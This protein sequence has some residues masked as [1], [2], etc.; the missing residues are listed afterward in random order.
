M[1]IR[2]VFALVMSAPAVL[3][4]YSCQPGITD[5][6]GQKIDSIVNFYNA[7]KPG[8]QLAVSLDGQVIYSKAWGMAD[9]ENKVPL[10]TETLIEAGSV[11]KQFTA[12]A[13]LLLEK[14]GKLSLDD[15]V[16]KYV[17]ALPSYGHPILIRHLIHHTSGLREWSDI[18]EIAGWP[19][20]LNVPDNQ[21]VLDII[22]RQKSLNSPPG[23]F[24]RYS[25]SNYILLALITEKVSGMTFADFTKKH[26]FE[27][28]GMAHTRWRNDFGEVVPMR[29]QAY[30]VKNAKFRSLMPD[31][32]IHGPGGLLTTAGDLLK[33]NEFY[34]SEKLGGKAMFAKQTA[35]DTLSNGLLNN[36]AAGLFIENNEKRVFHHG[37]ATAGYRAKLVCSP[38]LRLSI[39]WL[40]NTSMLD[41]TGLDPAMEVFK[42]LANSSDILPKPA[43][44]DSVHISPEQLTQFAGLYKSG[45]SG[46][47]V[48]ITSGAE[49]LLLSGTALKMLGNNRFRF[50]DITLSFDGMGELTVTPPSSEPMLYHIT[51][52]PGPAR[53]QEYAGKYYSQEANAWMEVK[54][55]NGKLTA[56]LVPRPAHSMEN[57]R[58]DGFLVPDLKADIVFKRD[59]H[60]NVTALEISTQ[61]SLRIVFERISDH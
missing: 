61:R 13:I 33:W 41:T 7:D 56:H 8:G 29:S 24:F 46:R 10:T 21:A 31:N 44:E 28:A 34:L 25:N 1:K 9:L 18:A 30:E 26:I 23:T 38:D 50:H 15:N 42:I 4:M 58:T 43:K 55:T 3:G 59:L 14:Q 49:G 35:L 17:P 6:T 53:P 48:E 47:D 2:S 20:A 57:Y 52:R 39:A 45:H 36:Y 12:A 60:N 32:A 16:V 37:G 19:L 54:N 5:V 11:S 22:C 27:P 51:D 40:S